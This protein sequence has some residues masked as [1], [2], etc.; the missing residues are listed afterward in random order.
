MTSSDECESGQT[1]F[2]ITATVDSGSVIQ[3]VAVTKLYKCS[4]AISMAAEDFPVWCDAKK[5][6]PKLTMRKIRSSKEVC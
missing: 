3:K 6:I 1:D 4:A 2:R 5:N